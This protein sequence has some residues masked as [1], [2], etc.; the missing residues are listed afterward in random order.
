MKMDKWNE[1]SQSILCGQDTEDQAQPIVAENEK[2]SAEERKRVRALALTAGVSL[3]IVVAVLVVGILFGN[4]AKK[5]REAR[6][7]R[8]DSPVFTASLDEKDKVTGKIT[9]AVTEVY[10]TVENGMMVTVEFYN[11]LETDEHISRVVITLSTEADAVIAKAATAGMKSDF[12]VPAGETNAITM[13]IKPEYV[14]ITDDPLETL[15]YEIT[16]DH[17]TRE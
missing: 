16:V 12:V 7:V 17:E 2:L 5:E 14:S 1:R 4:R 9:S 3:F 13:H 8:E 15:T 6:E 11:G 10:Y